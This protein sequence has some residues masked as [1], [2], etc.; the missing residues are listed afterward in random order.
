MGLCVGAGVGAGDGCGVL[1][2]TSVTVG[3]G[4]GPRVGGV[5]GAGHG[6]TVVAPP[7]TPAQSASSAQ[8]TI[9]VCMAVGLF[10]A[11]VNVAAGQNKPVEQPRCCLVQPRGADDS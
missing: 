5:E 3:W 4:E 6:A 11:W 2:G 8:R 10:S 9:H 1:V 7:A